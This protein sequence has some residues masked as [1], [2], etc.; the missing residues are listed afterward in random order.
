MSKNMTR[1]GLAFGAAVSLLGSVFASAPAQAVEL[2][3]GIAIAPASGPAAATAI[4][5]ADGASFAFRATPVNSAM[6]GSGSVKFKVTDPNAKFLPGA[7]TTG[8][9]AAN[10]ADNAAI[11]SNGDSN[12]VAVVTAS[13]PADGA[14]ILHSAT[15]VTADGGGADHIILKKDTMVEAYVNGG[16]TYF[17]SDADFTEA[18]KPTAV[19]GAVA[20][21]FFVKGSTQTIDADVQ[22]DDNTALADVDAAADTFSVQLTNF[23]LGAGDY[24]MFADAA[25]IHLD[26]NAAGNDLDVAAQDEPLTVTVDANGVATITSGT[27]GNL[28]AAQTHIDGAVSLVLFK[29]AAA[30]RAADSS[31]VVD[32]GVTTAGTTADIELLGTDA[33]KRDVSITAFVDDFS[34]NKID[35]GAEWTSAVKTASFVTRT[36]VAWTT[37]LTAPVIGNATLAATMTSSPMI[38]GAENGDASNFKVAFTRQDSSIVALS[39]DA[40]QSAVTGVWSTSVTTALGGNDITILNTT[41]GADTAGQNWTGLTAAAAANSSEISIA[42]TGVVTVKTGG[43]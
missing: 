24:V 16:V 6:A 20:N 39:G 30:V 34:N 32:T 43:K 7:N 37:S 4:Y 11:V 5:A 10:L 38:N 3:E 19:K 25:A 9:D 26:D 18:N 29:A 17:K 2:N 13:A 41:T 12:Y 31:F 14:Y 23:G 1:K 36:D 27:S 21:L 33:L 8:G 22:A 42:T 35:A 40:T 15:D 28:T